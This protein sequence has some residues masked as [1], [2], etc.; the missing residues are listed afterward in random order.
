MQGFRK[1]ERVSVK[2]EKCPHASARHDAGAVRPTRSATTARL[3]SHFSLFTLLLFTLISCTERATTYELEPIEIGVADGAKER[4]KRQRQLIQT[5]YNHVYQAPLP[6]AEAVAIDELLRSFG[7]SQVALEVVVAKMVSDADAALPT[8][9]ERRDDP[10]AFAARLYRRLYV[11]DATQ[12]ELSWWVNYLET[13]PD[14]DVAQV[15]FAF[16]TADEYR[17]Y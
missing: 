9:A 5:L 8:E 14:V 15:V 16:V 3:N 6:P 17:Y 11:R 7:D 2:S 10:E 1:C 4:T 13:H 12:A